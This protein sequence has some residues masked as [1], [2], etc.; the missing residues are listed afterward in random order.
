MPKISAAACATCLS[1]RRDEE[2][3][4]KQLCCIY[5]AVDRDSLD[6]VTAAL[7]QMMLYNNVT[8]GLTAQRELRKPPLEMQRPPRAHWRSCPGLYP[9]NIGSL[10]L[11]R[12]RKVFDT[13]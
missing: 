2:L 10:N 12:V 1:S 9:Y 11:K 8:A 5:A 13:P 7:A 3:S 6:K 4:A